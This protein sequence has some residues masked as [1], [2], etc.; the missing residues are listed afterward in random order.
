MWTCTGESLVELAVSSSTKLGCVYL[1]ETPS[2]GKKKEWAAAEPA[3][4]FLKHEQLAASQD[5]FEV[6]GIGLCDHYCPPLTNQGPIVL[7]GCDLTDSQGLGHE[8]QHMKG[9]GGSDE[10]RALLFLLPSPFFFPPL[11]SFPAFCLAHSHPIFCSLPISIFSPSTF[12]LLSSFLLP[13]ALFPLAPWEAASCF[14]LP[15]TFLES[16]GVP[17]RGR[18]PATGI[19]KAKFVL[20]TKLWPMTWKQKWQR[21][22]LENICKWRGYA[23]HQPFLLPIGWKVGLLPAATWSQEVMLAGKPRM[24]EYRD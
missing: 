11:S 15:R 17:E 13:L 10:D 22:F 7:S 3:S 12:S 16:V 4:K 23:L 20:V 21:H 8:I 18:P 2:S 1:L 9:V 24:V 6:K 19:E 5:W 14:C